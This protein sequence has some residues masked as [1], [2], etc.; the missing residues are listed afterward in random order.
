MGMRSKTVFRYSC[1][2]CEVDLGEY[3]RGQAPEGAR[4]LRV[5]ERELSKHPSVDAREIVL[6]LDCF[7]S[8][9][10]VFRE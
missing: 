8:L 1:D 4:A 5:E 7:L 10:A 3:E 9:P 2:V 6:C